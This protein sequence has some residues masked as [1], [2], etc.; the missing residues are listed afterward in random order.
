MMRGL[1]GKTLPGEPGD[2]NRAGRIAIRLTV[3][4]ASLPNVV[5]LSLSFGDGAPVFSGWRERPG[6]FASC[7]PASCTGGGRTGLRRSC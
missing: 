3:L 4:F 7:W 1:T 5:G 2:G 6:P